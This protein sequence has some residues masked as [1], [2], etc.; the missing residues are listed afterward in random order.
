MMRLARLC[1]LISATLALVSPCR[2][3]NAYWQVQSGNVTAVAYDN[4]ALALQAG[5]AIVR[6]RQVV[7]WEAGWPET[8][9]PPAVIAFLLRRSNLEEYFGK[10]VTSLGD[11]LVEYRSVPGFSAMLGETAIVMAPVLGAQ[12]TDEL[13]AL[14]SLYIRSLFTHGPTADWHPCVQFGLS[15]AAMSAR[16]TNGDE[17]YIPADAVEFRIVASESAMGPSEVMG[18]PAP[19][20]ESIPSQ[21]R[22]GFSCYTLAML[23]LREDTSGQPAYRQYF[24]LLANG[25]S[26]EDAARMALAEDDVALT[27][28]VKDYSFKLRSQPRLLAIRTKLPVQV[29]QWPEA[30]PLSAERVNRTLLA[31]K[32]KMTGP[33]P[34]ADATTP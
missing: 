16:T 15:L 32:E 2:A 30:Q 5:N 23:A 24:G 1:L 34:A 21:S 7:A 10:T 6:L 18:L 17:L 4:K 13:D 22:R 12:G 26:Y 9:Q 33:A 31:L 11:F 19:N 27:R 25:M 8:Y 14:T 3:D 29:V 28:K 20:R